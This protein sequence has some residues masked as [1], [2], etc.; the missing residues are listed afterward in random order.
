MRLKRLAIASLCL[1]AL[2][3]LYSEPADS[4]S[5]CMTTP[6]QRPQAGIYPEHPLSPLES[7]RHYEVVFLGEVVVPSRKCSLGFCAGIRVVQGIKGQSPAGN[8]VQITKPGETQ[9]GPAYFISKGDRWL[10]FANRGTSKTGLQYIYAE[11]LGPSFPTQEIPDFNA[12]ETR[13]RAIRSA[14]DQALEERLGPSRW[15]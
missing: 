8:L 1:L 13:Y 5:P 11:D 3:P 2:L 9:C 4:R 15:R 7:L 14:L 12:L 10:V 6:S